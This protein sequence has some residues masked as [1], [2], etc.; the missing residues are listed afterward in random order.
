MEMAQNLVQSERVAS[1]VSEQFFR[2]AF[3]RNAAAEDVCSIQSMEDALVASDG[4]LKEML[5]AMV[6]TD[7]FRFRRNLSGQ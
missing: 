7:A 4:D 5:V 6:K 1:C 3:A 2:Y